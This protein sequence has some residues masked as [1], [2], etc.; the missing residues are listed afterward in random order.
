MRIIDWVDAYCGDPLSD[1]ARTYYLLSKAEIS[2]KNYALKIIKN[3]IRKI[4]SQ[5]YLN[6]YFR[7]KKIPEKELNI[8]S[9]I[10]QISRY[11]EG[12]E[13]EIPYLESSISMGI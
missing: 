2:E 11:N 1:V 7:N 13:K 3:I 6:T 9:L 12:I 5:E 4:I 8:W 10:I